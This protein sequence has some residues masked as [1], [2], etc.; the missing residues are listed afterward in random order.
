MYNQLLFGQYITMKFAD[1]YSSFEQFETDFNELPFTVEFKDPNTLS[2]IYYLLYSKY[3]N[4]TTL[5][6]DINQFKF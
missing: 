6:T 5:S 2:I 3:G 1:I 4:S